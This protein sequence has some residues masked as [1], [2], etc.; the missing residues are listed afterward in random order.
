MNNHGLIVNELVDV[1][2]VHKDKAEDQNVQ[3]EDPGGKLPPKHS[4]YLT[5]NK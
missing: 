2:N 5:H 4:L 3:L 1:L